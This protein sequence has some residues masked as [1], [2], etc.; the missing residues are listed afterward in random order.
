[1]DRVNTKSCIQKIEDG[2]VLNLVVIG[3][4]QS[5]TLIGVH[6]GIGSM[7]PCCTKSVVW[8][9]ASILKGQSSQ[10]TKVRFGFIT[11]DSK[12]CFL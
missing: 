3:T 2:F 12:I 9:D 1:M 5:R 11:N 8:A 7:F 10:V 4:N 6:V